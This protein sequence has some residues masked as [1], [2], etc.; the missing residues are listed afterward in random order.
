[1]ESIYRSVFEYTNVYSITKSPAAPL[2]GNTNIFPVI[3]A[4]NRGINAEKR[5]EGTFAIFLQDKKNAFISM[6]GSKRGRC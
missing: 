3:S 1:M 6:G 4:Q 2:N 5:S